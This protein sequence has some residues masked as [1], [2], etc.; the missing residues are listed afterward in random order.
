MVPPEFTNFFIAGTSAGAALV[1]LLF[2]AVSIA[3]E[4]MVTF[5][6]PVE[7]QAVAGSAFTAL[8]NAFFISLVALIPRVNFGTLILPFSILSLLSSLVQAS[9]LLRPRK[10]WPSFLRRA[11]LALSS[12][13]LYGFE[14]IYAVDL[15]TNPSQVGFVYAVVFL[16]LSVF[17]IGLVRAW[18]LLGAQRYGF[19]GWLSPL[20]D[21]NN[22]DSLSRADNSDSAS[23]S[24]KTGETASRPPS[25]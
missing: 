21:L 15:I 9:V 23:G 10:S 4:Q 3:P 7:R 16:L 24:P 25:Q 17:A 1:G 5:R 20:H 19:I 6:A 11:F 2:V 12:I 14:V 8:M 18:E 13:V 22:T